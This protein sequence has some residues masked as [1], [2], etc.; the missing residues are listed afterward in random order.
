[1]SELF[2]EVEVEVYVYLMEDIEKVKK[3]MLNFILDLEFEVFDR[4]DYIIFIVK[5]RSRKVFSRFYE[6]FRGQVIFDIVRSFFEEGYFGEEIIIKV[7]K[8][9]VYVGVVNFNEESLFGLIMIIIRM[10]DL[11]RF[12]KW[13]VL[14]IKDGVLIE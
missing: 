4:G 10:K 12:M 9:V 14:R 6:F 8:Q 1:M 13:F 3:V 5:I 11:Q 7:N 2:E